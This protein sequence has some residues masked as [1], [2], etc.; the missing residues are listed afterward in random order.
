MLWGGESIVRANMS[1]MP[2]T[3]S[4]KVSHGTKSVCWVG[5]GERLALRIDNCAPCLGRQGFS[6]PASAFPPRSSPADVQVISSLSYMV[7]GDYAV[8]LC[9]GTRWLGRGMTIN[10]AP[11]K[12]ASSPRL[13]LCLVMTASPP[14]ILAASPG[15]SPRPSLSC[16][17]SSSP[18][19][20]AT[21]PPPPLT[22]PRLLNARFAGRWTCRESRCRADNVRPRTMSC[23]PCS[24]TGKVPRP[25]PA[26]PEAVH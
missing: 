22:S 1:S 16:R 4:A 2:P 12:P 20:T 7:H 26:S 14:A 9:H 8:T 15:R 23:L 18:C 11:S 19:P 24:G 13:C 6:V 3:S 10:D 21:A 17:C 25:L 5:M